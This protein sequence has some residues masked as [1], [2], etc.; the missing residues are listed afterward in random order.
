M[1]AVWMD[2]PAINNG[3]P[4]ITPSAKK[5]LTKKFAYELYASSSTCKASM[6]NVCIY[7][8]MTYQLREH[9]Q[10]LI[11]LERI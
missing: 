3:C 5:Y 1:S 10:W 4:H 11:H 8:N 9:Y 6:I 7:D 2:G